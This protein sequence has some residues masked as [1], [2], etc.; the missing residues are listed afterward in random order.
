MFSPPSVLFKKE[1]FLRNR[2][3][4]SSSVI[5]ELHI[6]S[7]SIGV[8]TGKPEV[9][10]APTGSPSFVTSKAEFIQPQ[11]LINFQLIK[12]KYKGVV[13]QL[14]QPHMANGYHTGQNR[15]RRS[16]SLHKVLLGSSGLIYQDYQVQ[17]HDAICR[18]A[19]LAQRKLIRLM[20]KEENSV[21]PSHSILQIYTRTLLP[22]HPSHIH[23]SIPKIETAQ[24]SITDEW[25]NKMW[26]I[27]IVEYY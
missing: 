14:S 7:S 17:K 25:I 26:F 11:A 3:L 13:S 9:G 2:E 18:A 4:E 15:Y 23:S 19:C 27:H 22:R 24:M 21:W 12:I 6:F 5:T 20:L 10:G 8:L 1:R 16:P